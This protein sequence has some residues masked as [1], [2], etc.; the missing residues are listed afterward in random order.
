MEAFVSK[1]V[2][3]SLIFQYIYEG[4]SVINIVNNDLKI[5]KQ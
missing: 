3:E 1:K 4:M 2:N 5:L